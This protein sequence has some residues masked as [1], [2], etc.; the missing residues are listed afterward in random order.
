MVVVAVATVVEAVAMVVEAVAMVVKA[1][2]MVVEAVAMV[3]EAVAMGMAAV[4]MLVETVSMVAVAVAMVGAEL[5]R[6]FHSRVLSFLAITEYSQAS[7]LLG[8]FASSTALHLVMADLHS[9]ISR[10]QPWRSVL[11]HHMANAS[12]QQEHVP[13]VYRPLFWPQ[14]MSWCPNMSLSRW[15]CW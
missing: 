8:F 9:N 7:L 2:A 14:M 11:I 5:V 4:A 12:V 10:K 6:V 15:S 13:L 3:V 1:V